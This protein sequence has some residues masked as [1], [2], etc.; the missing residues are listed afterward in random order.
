MIKRNRTSETKAVSLYTLNRFF[1]CCWI[2]DR[3]DPVISNHN[4]RM[5]TALIWGIAGKPVCVRGES[6][7]AKTKLTNA[8]VALIYGDSALAGG[9]RD[10]VL[11]TSG[12]AKA[13]LTETGVKQFAA[14]ESCYI[15]ELQNI[16]T[17]QDFEAMLKLW[18]EGR[19]YI[20]NRNIAKTDK[21]RQ[22]ILEPLPVLT[23]LAD[24]N[25]QLP[26]LP[27]EMQRRII[28]L[29][30]ESNRDLNRRVHAQKARLRYLPDELLPQL[31]PDEEDQLRL[32]IRFARKIEETVINPSASVVKDIIPAR[33]TLSNTF[34]DY[35]FDVIEAITKFHYL[36]RYNNGQYLFSTP[37]D[38]YLAYLIAGDIF[39]DSS[40]GIHSLGQTIINLVPVI[41]NIEYGSLK[42]QNT[43]G[44]KDDKYQESSAISKD[45]IIDRLAKGGNNRHRKV[46]DNLISRLIDS[47]YLR[48]VENKPFY[49]RT[50]E[51]NMEYKL[52][53]PKLI[54]ECENNIRKY[55]PDDLDNYMKTVKDTYINPLT[56]ETEKIQ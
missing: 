11:L 9:S 19:P 10:L 44:N 38:N 23:N 33:Y 51:V 4:T 32:Q 18:M 7:S 39:R 28:N 8:T 22:Y 14:A 27:L 12:S 31:E 15:P 2:N 42:S 47:N 49:Y 56:G 36:E 30:T 1:D 54:A 48:Q 55:Y 16:L 6:G 20:Y 43:F 21:T 24:G 13:A 46:I 5:L 50:E 17:S 26:D 37:E 41:K 52:D 35:F 25:E 29:P 3:L 40:I 53:V 45:K 34:I